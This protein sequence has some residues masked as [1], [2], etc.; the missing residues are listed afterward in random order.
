MDTKPTNA[1]DEPENAITGDE[2]LFGSQDA[3]EVSIKSPGQYSAKTTASNSAP[4]LIQALALMHLAAHILRLPILV[5]D[6]LRWVQSGE[7]LYLNAHKL[8][9]KEMS[10][11]L[12]ADYLLMLNMKTQLT[13]AAFLQE[14]SHMQHMHNKE[15]GID[16]PPLNIPPLL[17]RLIEEL[18]LPL[19][20]YLAVRRLAVYLELD[21]KYA[22]YT[23]KKYRLFDIPE[24]Q[25][26]ACIIIVLKLFY[27]LDGVKRQPTNATSPSTVV[28]DWNLW[29]QTIGHVQPLDYQ[30]NLQLTDEEVIELSNEKIDDYFDFF[31][32]HFTVDDPKDKDADAAYRRAVLD[33]FPL[34][35]LSESN[36][37]RL[38]AVVDRKQEAICKVQESLRPNRATSQDHATKPGAKV[39]YHKNADA[40]YGHWKIFYEVASRVTGMSVNALLTVVINVEQRSIAT[41]KG[42]IARGRPGARRMPSEISDF[43]VP[44]ED[45]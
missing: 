22:P 43:D 21:F 6:W 14:I 15:F 27:D 5:A 30:Q 31:Q 32:E 9:P 29:A 8:I 45:R 36:S 7:I 20:V 34:P 25:L 33:L 24:A 28:V 38:Q 39:V 26:I 18:A 42:K 2:V 13:D 35:Q 19:E 16:M 44:L 11:R 12:R 4:T 23:G 1:N 37:R 40:F 41:K 17:F 3:T 10:S